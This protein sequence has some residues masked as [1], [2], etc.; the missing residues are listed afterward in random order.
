MWRE[1]RNVYIVMW[2]QLYK[3]VCESFWAA[4]I[5]ACSNIRKSIMMNAFRLGEININL[6]GMNDEKFT[7]R[8][9]KTFP[10]NRRW[11]S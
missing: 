4:I 2:R 3:F 10:K 8:K 9:A 11:S 6:P 1:E 5:C 7:R